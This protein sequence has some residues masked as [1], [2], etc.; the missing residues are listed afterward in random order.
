MKRGST[1]VRSRKRFSKIFTAEI[2]STMNGVIYSRAMCREV[3]KGVRGTIKLQSSLSQCCCGRQSKQ[4]SWSAVDLVAQRQLSEDL[5]TKI[6]SRKYKQ[7][8]SKLST[9]KI[10]VP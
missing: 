4:G 3:E 6:M 10:V 2:V 8:V 5:D 9:S 1:R 7:H